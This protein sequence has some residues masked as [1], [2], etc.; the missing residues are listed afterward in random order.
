MHY[1]EAQTKPYPR[2]LKRKVNILDGFWD[3]S[4]LGNDIDISSLPSTFNF[5]TVMAVPGVFDASPAYAGKRGTAVYRTFC[6]IPPGK[7]SKLHFH[8]TGIWVRIIVDGKILKECAL[9]YSGFD[10]EVPSSTNSTRELC[11]VVDNRFDFKRAPLQEQFFDFYAYG[12]IFRS[13]EWHELG[14]YSINRAQI[15]TLDVTAGIIRVDVSLTG[16]IPDYVDLNVS[17]NNKQTAELTNRQVIDGAVCFEL[18]MNDPTP[19]NC[20]APAL[21]EIHIST[22][23]DDIIERFGLRTIEARN[24]K[25]LLNGKDVKLLGF[26]RHESHPQ[27]GPALPDAQLISDLQLLKDLNCNFIR[28]SHYPQCQKFLDLCDEMGFLVMEE[29][30]GW[31]QDVRHFES[32]EYFSQCVEQTRLMVEN[33]FNHP[34]VIFRG[35]LNEAHSNK[36]ESREIYEALTETLRTADKTRPV[37]FASCCFENDINLDLADIICINMYPGWYTESQENAPSQEIKPAIRDVI[38]RIDAAGHADKPF[39]L[40]EIGIGAIYG[41]HDNFRGHWS[42][43]YQSDCLTEI[44]EEVVSNEKINGVALWQFCDCRTASYAEKALARP[45]AFNNKGI[46]DEY[47]RPKMA[48]AN[49]KTVFDSVKL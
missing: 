23:E 40:S 15:T 28:G 41:W 19:W 45:R 5:D 39:I 18:E 3:F 43:E 25:I 29:S 33:G 30:L 48:C 38:K 46:F 8:G 16:Q 47:R 37:G 27:F 4:F 1:P 17:I 49:V 32:A 9:P 2:F 24:R 21:H 31:Q 6:S 11:V 36:P 13:V 14:E 34:S 42:E 20:S 35:F 7:R 10:V 12:G 22:G 26:C 44:C